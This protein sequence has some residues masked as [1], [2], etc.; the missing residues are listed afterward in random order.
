MKYSL[1]NILKKLAMPK[2]SVHGKIIESN[3]SRVEKNY[4]Y[5][6]RIGYIRSPSYVNTHIVRQQLDHEFNL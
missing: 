3:P 5:L 2:I 4:T 6:M 1:I